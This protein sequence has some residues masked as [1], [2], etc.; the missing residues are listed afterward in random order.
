[1]LEHVRSFNRVVTQSIGALQ[2]H[3]LSRSLT[4]GAARLL[5]EVQLRLR[6]AQR[7]VP[8]VPGRRLGHDQYLFE[9]R[10]R[11]WTRVDAV[12]FARRSHGMSAVQATLARLRPAKA[13]GA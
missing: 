8:L 4:L 10:D 3:Y 11:V 9:K 7:G 13:N 6:E 5:W 12:M 2:D 1:M